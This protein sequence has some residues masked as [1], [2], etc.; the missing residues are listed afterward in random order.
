MN[1]PFD[2]LVEAL[3]R[4]ASRRL[5]RRNALSI[6]GR[7]L[8][9][10]MLVPLLPVDRVAHAQAAPKGKDGLPRGWYPDDAVQ[11]TDPTRCD[12][13]RYCASNGYMCA[14]CGGTPSACPPGTQPSPSSWIG[15]CFNPDENKHYIIAYRDCCGNADACGRCECDGAKGEKPPYVPQ[16]NSDVFW[17]FGATTMVYNCS[18]AIVIGEA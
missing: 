6:L 7:A 3:A 1:I 10:G 18:N 13:W 2:A 11:T 4:G 5:S 8:L 17:C 14:C 15:T 16:R 12:Y 9:G